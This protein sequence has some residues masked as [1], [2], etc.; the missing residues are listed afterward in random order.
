MARNETADL[1]K[2]AW[3]SVAASI[4]TITL[5]AGA[6]YITGSVSLL[7]DALESI[8]N[9]VAAIV[10]L[11][12]LILASR[13]ANARYTFGRS[14]AEYFS[15]AIEGSMIFVAAGLIIFTAA[16]RLFSPRPLENVGIGL[17]VSILASVLNGIVSVVL[18]RAGKRYSSPTL[19]ADGKHLWTDVITSIG[20]VIGVILVWITGWE[21]LDPIVAILVGCNIIYVGYTLVTTSLAGLMDVTLPQEE[22]QAIIAVLKDF[23]TDPTISFHG[24]QTRES[25]QQRMVKLDA[26]V[27]GTWT[28]REGHDFA[29]RVVSAIEGK[30][31]NASVFIHIEPIED[32]E[33]YNDIPQ[34]FVPLGFDGLVPIDLETG[35]PIRTQP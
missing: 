26:Q 21:R 30:I 20:V 19:V 33:S 23:A 17:L 5:K 7:S 32:P 4:A 13:P 9:L 27:P 6:Y 28:V 16:E 1:T 2:Y 22:N 8:V 3:L 25:G 31:P 34:G 14:K 35:K 18:V 12:A 15:A 11:I 10:A 29:H 24:L